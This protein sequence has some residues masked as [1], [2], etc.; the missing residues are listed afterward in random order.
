MPDFYHV[1]LCHI[2]VGQIHHHH[3]HHLSD[4]SYLS[5]ISHSHGYLIHHHDLILLSSWSTVRQEKSRLSNLH[6]G[7]GG[8]EDQVEV[9]VVEE[10][11]TM[12]VAL[13]G[14]VAVIGEEDLVV[15]SNP[16]FISLVVINA[17]EE[18][19]GSW[20]RAG[21]RLNRDDSDDDKREENA[22][23]LVADGGGL[24]CASLTGDETA[25]QNM[26]PGVPWESL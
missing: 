19:E 13:R 1:D 10:E 15:Q 5:P 24:F 6:R 14:E 2:G 12:M 9:G 11:V 26:S 4:S 18:N 3:H 20:R 23:K 8:E 7:T 16:I 17:S 22:G 25:V 21:Q